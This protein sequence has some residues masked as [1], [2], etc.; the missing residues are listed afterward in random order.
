LAGNA[1]QSL[2]RG[3][4]LEA[5]LQAGLIGSPNQIEAIKANFGKRSPRFSD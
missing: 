4:R 3:L 1:A 2:K 5:T